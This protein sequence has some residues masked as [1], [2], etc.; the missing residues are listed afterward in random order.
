[1]ALNPESLASAYESFGVV[2]LR[3]RP[4]EGGVSPGNLEASGITAVDITDLMPL[5][6]SGG[7]FQ[8]WS[9]P[10]GEAFTVTADA[11]PA[12]A[13]TFT[14]TFEGE[15]TAA[16]AFDATAAAVAAALAAL[17]NLVAA[18]VSV[19]ASGAGSDLGDAGH[20]LTITFAGAWSGMP[21]ALT[22]DQTSISAGNDFVLANTV[23]GSGS[24]EI[25]GFLVA[26]RGP[27]SHH[28]T[29][30]TMISVLRRG[31]VQ[32]EDVPL[33]AG[34]TRE[35]LETALK[36]ADLRKQGLDIRGLEGVA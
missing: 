12:S 30:D 20:V 14:L 2:R 26:P 9:A 22:A 29:L 33:P 16:I 32:A 25:A 36:H 3:Y 5:V 18:D 19:V 21:V 24:L 17:S 23:T 34:Q 10:V 8:L 15:T 35:N 4:Y 6:F 13:G 31:E 11:T 27:V 28:Q 1:M 7:K